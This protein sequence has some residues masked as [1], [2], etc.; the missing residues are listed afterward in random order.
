MKKG[1]GSLEYL[2]MVAAVLAIAAVVV[3][4]MTGAFKTGTKSASLARCEEAFAQCQQKRAIVPNFD[5]YSLCETGCSGI[6]GVR[7]GCGVSGAKNMTVV[8]NSTN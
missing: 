4:F 6:T 1:Q 5:C 2:I 8:C 3:L 7:T